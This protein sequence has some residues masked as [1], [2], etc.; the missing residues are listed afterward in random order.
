MAQMKLP[1]WCVREEK[2]NVLWRKQ[3]GIEKTRFLCARN[4]KRAT[5]IIFVLKLNYF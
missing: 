3:R 2:L 4:F 5:R 1:Y